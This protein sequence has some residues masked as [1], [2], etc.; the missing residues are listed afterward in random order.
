[1]IQGSNPSKGKRFITSP[2]HPDWF[3]LS[4][5]PYCCLRG[6]KGILQA[7]G[8]FLRVYRWGKRASKYVMNRKLGGAQSHSGCLQ[9]M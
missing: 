6:T 2:K 8:S 3:C 7:G 1:M 4:S 5:S 9:M